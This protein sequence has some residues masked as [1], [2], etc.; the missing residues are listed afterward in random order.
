MKTDGT[1]NNRQ[2][3]T[4]NTKTTDKQIDNVYKNKK[5]TSNTSS[6]NDQKNIKN[7]ND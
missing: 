3:K 4:S 2:T 1:L 7:V 5:V 6:K